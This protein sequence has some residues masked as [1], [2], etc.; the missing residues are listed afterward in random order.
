MQHT[1]RRASIYV[2]TVITVAM[3]VSLIL[4]GTILRNAYNASANSIA[5][6][7]A[8][9]ASL[10]AG[11]ELALASV[12]D[13]PD[14]RENAKT[15]TVYPKTVID[16]TQ[17]TTVVYDAATQSKATDDTEIYRIT[18]NAVNDYTQQHA[19]FDV[20]LST[21]EYTTH[22]SDISAEH[23]W[24]LT[25]ATKAATA[26]EDIR[27]NDGTY[28]E[29]NAGAGLNDEGAPVPV[30]TNTN[31]EIEIP[32]SVYFKQSTGS[33]SCWIYFTG[34]TNDYV[35]YPFLGMQYE[36]GGDPNL[37]C[38]IINGALW[39]YVNDTGSYSFSKIAYTGFNAVTANTWH[40]IVVT[41]GNNRLRAYIDGTQVAYNSSNND[42]V[43]TDS[44]FSG[45]EQ[46]LRVGAGYDFGSPSNKRGF[47]GSVAH[48]AYYDDD[49]TD[50][51]IA[52]LA[53]IRPDEVSAQI[54]EA[55]WTPL[56]DQ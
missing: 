6:L 32:W 11:V 8:D 54:V 9:T 27:G 53:A 30:F 41:W 19:L 12:L 17:Y 4:I 38:A 24:P 39:V 1:S 23:Y 48:L 50:D 15:G 26:A 13:D 21:Y 16:D 47:L 56:H 45:G 10:N 52:D 3:I 36:S 5:A 22:I 49:L 40:H 51:E 42:G 20:Q 33:L 29:A 44:P 55:S 18:V 2:I 14:F 31:D 46:P 34:P 37:N 28:L 43:D 7:S 35:F 25:D